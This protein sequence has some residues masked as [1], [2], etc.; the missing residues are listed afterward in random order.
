MNSRYLLH[1]AQQAHYFGLPHNMALASVTSTP[2]SVLGYDHRIGYIKLGYD[3]DVVLWDSHPLA[4]GATPRQ[5][6]IDGIAQITTPYV[7]PKPASFQSV[8]K[9][10]DFSQE[11]DD[12]LKY[13]GLPPLVPRRSDSDLVVFTNVHSVFLKEGDGIREAFSASEAGVSGNV[14]VEKGE[15][16]C[17]GVASTCSVIK[18]NAN[19][20]QVDLEG[21]TISPALVSYGNHLGLNHID[22]EPSTNDGYVHDSLESNPPNIIGEGSIIKAVDGLQFHTRDALLAYRSGVTTGITAPS[23]NGFLAG[24]STAFNTGLPHRLAKGAVVQDIAAKRLILV[25]RLTMPSNTKDCRL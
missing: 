22:G 16:V 9:T 8:P 4:L 17:M 19:I 12:A 23:S 6:F 10:P 21:G 5:V 3:A 24:L 20:Q 2:A 14:V 7:N 15:I 25:K 11:A 1:D 13:E 18:H